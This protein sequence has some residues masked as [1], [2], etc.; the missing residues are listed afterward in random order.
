MY[1]FFFHDWRHTLFPSGSLCIPPTPPKAGRTP[2]SLFWILSVESS[3]CSPT[4]AG[5]VASRTIP[6]M[7]KLLSTHWGG[8]VSHSQAPG[9]ECIYNNVYWRS[10]WTKWAR[11][12]SREIKYGYC[13]LPRAGNNCHLCVVHLPMSCFT[14]CKELLQRR[15]NLVITITLFYI[16]PAFPFTREERWSSERLSALLKSMGKWQNEIKTPF[17]AFF[18]YISTG[19]PLGH[20]GTTHISQPRKS[21]LH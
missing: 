4:V 2:Y 9:I 16:R 3:C 19:L 11:E 21:Q 8:L 13:M 5:L 6:I 1:P 18:L 20:S 14:F 17:P 7:F 10:E 12:G 15:S